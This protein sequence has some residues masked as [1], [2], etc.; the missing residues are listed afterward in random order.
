MAIEVCE[1]KALGVRFRCFRRAHSLARFRDHP[2]LLRVY[3][4]EPNIAITISSSRSIIF[5]GKTSFI[6]L[7][8]FGGSAP[9]SRHRS[10]HPG[11]SDGADGTL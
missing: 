11:E 8:H 3:R 9:C 1:T 2:L 6:E 7:G 10:P 5:L 4:D